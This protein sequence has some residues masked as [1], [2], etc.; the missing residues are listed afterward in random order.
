MYE[1]L[2][3]SY[4]N[5]FSRGVNKCLNIFHNLVFYQ[6]YDFSNIFCTE[7]VIELTNVFM[8]FIV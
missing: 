4:F 7:K 6:L 8:F 5:V 1:I 3:M 2:V